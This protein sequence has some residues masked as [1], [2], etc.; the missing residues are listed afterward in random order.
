MSLLHLTDGRA[1]GRAGWLPGGDPIARASER[2]HPADERRQ[3]FV[4]GSDPIELGP[5]LRSAPLIEAGQCRV[6]AD[7]ERDAVT[8][9]CAVGICAAVPLG[10]GAAQILVTAADAVG[11]LISPIFF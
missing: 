9:A 11:R 4:P 5:V 8:M 10:I 3:T 7:T 1:D 2:H 6:V